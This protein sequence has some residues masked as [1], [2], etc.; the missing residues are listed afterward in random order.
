M[1]SGAEII[2]QRLFHLATLGQR[3]G[4]V[5]ERDGIEGIA[6]QHSLVGGEC[7]LLVG[8]ETVRVIPGVRQLSLHLAEAVGVPESLYRRGARVLVARDVVVETRHATPGHGKR[9]VDSDGFLEERDRLRVIER[10]IEHDRGLRVLAKCLERTG[11]DAIECP[12]L[13]D[14]PQRLA[15]FRSYLLA[16]PADRRDQVV[17]AGR[18]LVERGELVA[19]RGHQSGGQD[20]APAEGHDIAIQDRL[21]ALTG[22]DRAREIEVDP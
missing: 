15:R 19:V 5:V 7:T 3:V 6:R 1:L 12:R 10:L 18:F 2:A 16:E 20:V 22:G 21:D 17:L 4:T 13:A 11:G 8:L 9:R 14:L